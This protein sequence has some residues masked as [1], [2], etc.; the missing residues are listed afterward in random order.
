MDEQSQ[1]FPGMPTMSIA[2]MVEA[3]E[4]VIELLKQGPQ[5]S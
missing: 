4:V 2:T 1:E 5:A 3:I